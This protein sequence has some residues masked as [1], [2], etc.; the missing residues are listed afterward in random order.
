MELLGNKLTIIDTEKI[1]TRSVDSDHK[2]DNE[3]IWTR[4]KEKKTEDI[5]YYEQSRF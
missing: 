5:R 3:L 2:T 1:I 4:E